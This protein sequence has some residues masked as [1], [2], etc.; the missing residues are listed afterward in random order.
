MT[1]RSGLWRSIPFYLPELPQC[2]SPRMSGLVLYGRACPFSCTRTKLSSAFCCSII[3][4]RLKKKKVNKEPQ[5]IW[6]CQKCYRQKTGEQKKITE[7]AFLCTS[8]LTM[9]NKKE[10]RN[11]WR[12]FWTFKLCLHFWRRQGVRLQCIEVVLE[13]VFSYIKSCLLSDLFSCLVKKSQPSLRDQ[14]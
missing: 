5:K 12:A 4:R 2:F 7:P 10:V 9:N 1:P 13:V 14:D 8:C 3:K 6:E 11:L